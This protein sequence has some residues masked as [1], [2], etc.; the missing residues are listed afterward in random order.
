[1][2]YKLYK[3]QYSSYAHV[4]TCIIQLDMGNNPHIHRN[5]K[6]MV[7]LIFQTWWGCNVMFW[8]NHCLIR[9][10]WRY[11]ILGHLTWPLTRIS[12]SMI[13]GIETYGGWHLEVAYRQRNSGSL[14]SC[15]VYGMKLPRHLRERIFRDGD[16]I[17][18]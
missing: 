11:F 18:D 10:H 12:S 7:S 15:S 5:K 3:N 14:L 17:G 4:C 1:M 6:L 13:I 8:H 16:G 2:R 9:C